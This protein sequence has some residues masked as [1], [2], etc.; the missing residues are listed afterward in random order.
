[1]LLKF[2]EENHDELEGHEHSDSECS[3]LHLRMLRMQP[4]SSA[5]PVH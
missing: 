4:L 1:M 3:L 5:Q 2:G